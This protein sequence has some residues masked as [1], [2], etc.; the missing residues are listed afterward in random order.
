M[1]ESA[2]SSE[3]QVI[4]KDGDVAY[5]IDGWAV[6]RPDNAAVVQFGVLQ[7]DL[8]KRNDRGQISSLAQFDGIVAPGLILAQHIFRGLKRPLYPN[9][10]PN[11]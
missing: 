8:M 7:T 5:L 2:I 3:P 10:P 4:N 9:F 6:D 11:L 1:G